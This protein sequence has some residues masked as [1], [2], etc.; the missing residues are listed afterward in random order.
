[1]FRSGVLRDRSVSPTSGGAAR[2]K[3]AS[4]TSRTAP[5]SRAQSA[6]R[7]NNVASS[8]TRLQSRAQGAAI[9]KPGGSSF[10]T[11][12]S[13]KRRS[14]AAM[15]GAGLTERVK[16]LLNRP[17]WNDD[18]ARAP[19]QLFDPKDRRLQRAGKK[20]GVETA[21]EKAVDEKLRL[22]RKYDAIDSPPGKKA[23]LPDDLLLSHRALSKQSTSSSSTT[24]S[25]SQ[26]R[27]PARAKAKKPAT[28]LQSLRQLQAATAGQR[29]SR[30]ALSTAKGI[31]KGVSMKGRHAAAR[32]D[33][34]ENIAGS[35]GVS[36]KSVS[37]S[38][39]EDVLRSLRKN[40]D[41]E[42]LVASGKKLLADALA[43]PREGSVSDADREY[44]CG[45][46]VPPKFRSV[47][48]E[49][50]PATSLSIQECHERERAN[51][52][53]RQVAQ[54]GK[55]P[56]QLRKPKAG[57]PTTGPPVSYALGIPEGIAQA[58]GERPEVVDLDK[59]ERRVEVAQAELRLRR[60]REQAEQAKMLPLQLQPYRAGT[61]GHP[62]AENSRTGNRMQT[63]SASSPLLLHV[64]PPMEQNSVKTLA[65]IRA[66]DSVRSQNLELD[67]LQERNRNLQKL[68][69]R[70]SPP[71]A[72][73]AS[74][75][76][77]PS[78]AKANLAEVQAERLTLA[79]AASPG[80]YS[81]RDIA[82]LTHPPLRAAGPPA[83]LLS[84]KIASVFRGNRL[85]PASPNPV[86]EQHSRQQGAA[87]KGTTFRDR[88]GKSSSCSRIPS[89][90]AVATTR[91]RGSPTTEAAPLA[92]RAEPPDEMEHF[93]ASVRA[94]KLAIEDRE[95]SI[96]DRIQQENKLESLERQLQRKYHLSGGSMD[97]LAQKFRAS[98]HLL[99][100]SV[101][102]FSEVKKQATQELRA[103]KLQD[104]FQTLP[105]G[106]VLRNLR[107][108]DQPAVDSG[109]NAYDDEK[110][111]DDADDDDRFL[112]ASQEP[113]TSKRDG[114]VARDS[115]AGAGSK[116]GSTKINAKLPFA[117]D[118]TAILAEE[119][120]CLDTYVALRELPRVSDTT[121]R[122][123]EN[124][125]Y[126][127]KRHL[128]IA[129]E[130]P[131]RDQTGT[132]W[133]VWSQ[134][135]DDIVKDIVNQVADDLDAG[136]DKEIGLLIRQETGC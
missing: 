9:A 66:L 6:H 34:A 55:V 72:A 37:S 7:R 22:L 18:Y 79:R 110:F 17:E 86:L 92:G 109:S 15:P 50:P 100:E 25:A 107:D 96:R 136:I 31:L 124:Y 49:Q 12:S 36:K 131:L 45:S 85:G 29:I 83:G 47:L 133:Q 89:P 93:M 5:A 74:E 38:G 54:R 44:L 128:Q 43:A 99:R 69:G 120:K 119:D 27:P 24:V 46:P 52:Q 23:A 123:L 39:G 4:P 95:K 114:V 40:P 30:S 73:F 28:S 78:P 106:Y 19:V 125:R 60:E 94:K 108:P 97:P 105:E 126:N 2:Q 32:S 101:K 102:S 3:K 76:P 117:Q 134:L 64:S 98:Q 59:V 118:G 104:R 135:A 129:R 71:D 90:N 88:K 67:R 21:L 70:G 121:F 42:M 10:N 63:P 84:S 20:M 87:V 116:M 16:H 53:N 58:L 1:M 75:N 127:F 91:H 48:S 80:S 65:E 122:E 77:S 56:A 113:T 112:L 51:R 13:A 57:S 103:Q 111:E 132:S 33:S 130:A 14:P 61:S 11:A 8:G 26:F 62:V 68:F 82:K 81:D 115:E 35:R 41:R